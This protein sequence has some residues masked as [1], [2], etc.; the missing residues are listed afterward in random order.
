MEIK[1]LDKHPEEWNRHEIF[2]DGAQRV[3]N[4]RR[5]SGRIGEGRSTRKWG[6]QN[7]R[8]KKPE[9]SGDLFL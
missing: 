2:V 4:Q 9:I 6:K 1:R 3:A 8:R 5:F 7:R